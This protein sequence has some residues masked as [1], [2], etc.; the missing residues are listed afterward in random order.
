ML[1]DKK[2]LSVCE[3]WNLCM[4]RG[5]IRAIKYH[6]SYKKKY[7]FTLRIIMNS[8]KQKK[9]LLKAKRKQR[10]DNNRINYLNNLGYGRLS[11]DHTKLNH[12]NTYAGLPDYYEGRDFTCIECGVEEIWTA[13]Q[14]K[15]YYEECKGHIDARAIRCKFCRNVLKQAKKEQLTQMQ[16][17]KNIR[18]HPNEIFFKDLEIFKKK[19]TND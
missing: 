7:E 10:T 3:I 2:N 12:I 19:S 18:T 11:S 8:N 9:K 14:Q 4:D 15:I 17:V 1:K 5:F 6:K 16:K 13:K